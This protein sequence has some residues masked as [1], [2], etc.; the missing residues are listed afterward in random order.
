MAGCFG[1]SDVDRWMERNLNDYL[2]DGEPG[3]RCVEF[4]LYKG[5]K[6]ISEWSSEISDEDSCYFEMKETLENRHIRELEMYLNE[7]KDVSGEQWVSYYGKGSLFV[8]NPDKIGYGHITSSYE[9]K[10]KQRNILLKW[11]RLP[12]AF[13][14]ENRNFNL[15][16]MGKYSVVANDPRTED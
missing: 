11:A 7:A 10:E 2:D 6:L 16:R 1:G 9:Q 4:K 8:S 12:K 13:H 3:S 14:I 15:M 5:K